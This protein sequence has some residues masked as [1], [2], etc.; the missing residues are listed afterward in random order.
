MITTS[1]VIPSHQGAQRLEILLECLSLQIADFEWEAIIVLDGS[2][3]NSLEVIDRWSA[4]V[5]VRAIDLGTNQGRPTA[6][7]TGF[8]AARGQ[9]LIRCD[10]D[11]A[12]DPLFLAH[13]AE[14]H[15]DSDDIGVIGLYDNVLPDSPYARA[16]GEHAH[17]LFLQT[18]RATPTQLLWRFWAGNCSVSRAIFDRVGPYDTAFRAYGWEDV[19]WGYRLSLAGATIRLDPR[20]EVP[21]HVAA[22]T[23]A[24]RS[25]RAYLSGSARTRFNE[26][27]GIVK[28]SN[29]TSDAKWSPWNT[30]V[31]VM[32]LVPSSIR[33]GGAH[34]VDR[35]GDRL[36]IG[37]TRKLI[38][39]CVESSGR[40]GVRSGPTAPSHLSNGI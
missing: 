2:T 13:H 1:V 4:T 28:D 17:S 14:H 16:Y 10:D 35:V 26:K 3:D 21:H 38:A 8:D 22:T 18:A 20:L 12:P 24:I 11:L 32:S 15:R 37:L 30:A 9:V 25:R 39:L 33:E 23:T 40:A 5:P 27:H 6:L 31:R 29:A 34:T 36:P 19:D 7:N